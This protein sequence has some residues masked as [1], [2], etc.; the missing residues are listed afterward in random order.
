MS[1]RNRRGQLTRFC[2]SSG[3]SLDMVAEQTGLQVD[4]LSKIASGRRE[5][6]ITTAL[7]IAAALGVEVE[8]LFAAPER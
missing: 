8:D 6:L 4:T 5:P 2:G 3:I 1:G 7:R